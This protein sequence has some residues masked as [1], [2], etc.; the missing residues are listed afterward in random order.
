MIQVK[1]IHKDLIIDAVAILIGEYSRERK[2]AAKLL[3]KMCLSKE[4]FTELMNDDELKPI[5]K[6][7]QVV[8]RSKD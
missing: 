7:L 4:Q 6:G 2:K 1:H 3:L 8:N 5:V